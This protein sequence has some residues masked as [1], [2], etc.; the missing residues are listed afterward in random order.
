MKKLSEQRKKD[1]AYKIV[2]NNGVNCF[3]ENVLCKL[4]NFSATDFISFDMFSSGISLYAVCDF[5]KMVNDYIKDTGDYIP[6]IK[7]PSYKKAFMAVPDS[8]TYLYKASV[9]KQILNYF[10]DD[11]VK[12]NKEYVSLIDFARFIFAC[13][14]VVVE[15]EKEQKMLF[16][17]AIKNRKRLDAIKNGTSPYLKSGG[18]VRSIETGFKKKDI[19]YYFNLQDLINLENHYTK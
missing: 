16:A 19:C 12:Y 3:S 10:K 1:I 17:N 7:V 6:S 13:Q 2:K 11:F 9:I 15:P 4:D 14:G 5:N 18:F 8:E